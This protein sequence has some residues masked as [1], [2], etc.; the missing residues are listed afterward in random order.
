LEY[1]VVHNGNGLISL[2]STK[3]IGFT[4][5]IKYHIVTTSGLQAFGSLSVNS[6]ICAERV[7]FVG[8]PTTI[9]LISG[10]IIGTQKLIPVEA[11]VGGTPNWSTFT[12]LNVPSWGTVTFNGD[13]EIVYT[14]TNILTTPTIPDTIKWSLQD[15]SGNQ[16][17]ITDTVLRDILAVPVTTTDTVCTSCSQVVSNIDLLANDTGDIDRSTVQIVLND[18][19]IVIA[20]DS[21]NNFTFT[22][23]AGASFNNLN[24]YK[25]ANTQGAFSATQNF[26]VR[27]ACVGTPN[28]RSKDLTCLVSKLF[29]IADEYPLA[30]CFGETFVETTPTL[31]TYASQGGVITIGGDVDLTGL[32]NKTYTFQ[33]TCQNQGACSPTYDDIGTLTVSHAAT[34]FVNITGFTNP[35]VGVYN[36]TFTYSG[37]IS[38]FSVTDDGVGATFKDG[39]VA[40]NGSGTFSLYCNA[41]SS[42]VISAT[43]VCGNIV[44]DTQVV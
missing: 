6:P 10:D 18:P 30:N 26:I 16:I 15:D 35:S 1:C 21:S 13:R 27:S 11:R 23:L 3:N 22:T 12:F 43:T 4:A 37:I 41:G 14:I 9:Q 36:F 17:N 29:N 31:P 20:K 8:T 25:V 19:N 40:N 34:P 28:D 44:T 32:V 42:I 24:S 38:Q 7:G 5:I 2:A 33:Y 39:I